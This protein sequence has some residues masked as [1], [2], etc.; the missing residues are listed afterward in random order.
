[1]VLGDDDSH[2]RLNH[3]DYWHSRGRTFA[4]GHLPLIRG[5]RLGV[6]LINAP[7][8]PSSCRHTGRFATATT[9]HNANPNRY[10]KP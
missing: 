5:V 1:M 7:A 10:L 3:E 6:W 9:D 8:A 4:P 2:G